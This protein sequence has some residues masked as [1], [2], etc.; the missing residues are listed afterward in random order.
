MTK[1][2]TKLEKAVGKRAVNV[3][4]ESEDYAK[5]ERAS[6]LDGRSVASLVRAWTLR[7]LAEELRPMKYKKGAAR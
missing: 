5:I 1:Q 4:F 6:D 7:Q 2:V 3:Q